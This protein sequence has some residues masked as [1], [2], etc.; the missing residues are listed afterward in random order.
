MYNKN[1]ASMI[2]IQQL[3]LF[4]RQRGCRVAEVG[5]LFKAHSVFDYIDDAYE[6]LH[7]QGA[8]ATYEDI[9]AYI[10]QRE[11]DEHYSV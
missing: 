10:A 6:F 4:K 7:I 2:K 9:S 5:R 8:N 3:E 11:N 1:I